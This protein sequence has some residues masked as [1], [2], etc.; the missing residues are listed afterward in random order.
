MRNLFAAAKLLLLDMASTFLFVVLLLLTQNIPLSVILGVALGVAQIG[1]EFVRKKPIDTMQW[2]S[3]FLV[4]GSGAA[5]LLTKD[6]RF[7]MVKPS[8]IYVVVGVVMLKPGWI[9]R[10]LPPVAKA[11]V[12]D[13]AVILGF[14]WS[15]LMFISA[16]VN[17]IAVLNFSM[18][19]WASFM[20]A[21]GIVSKAALFLIGYAGM[22]YIG[23]RRWRAMPLLERDSLTAALQQ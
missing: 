12:P 18:P 19:T 8:L 22:R 4:V 5:T 17:T 13:I 11:V 21:Y 1:W 6:P 23:N 14:A 10:Y 2:M 15:G 9:N 20:L 16:A 3:L 7:V